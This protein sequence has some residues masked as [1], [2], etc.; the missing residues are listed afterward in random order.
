MEARQ[1]LLV[2]A[3][4]GDAA[5]V[6]ARALFG[7]NVVDLTVLPPDEFGRWIVKQP[8][9]ERDAW[10]KACQLFHDRLG[11]AAPALQSPD[12]LGKAAPAL[13]SPDRLGK[14][15]PALQSPARDDSNK[16]AVIERTRPIRDKDGL[17]TEMVKERLML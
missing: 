9:P 7:G 17:I 3:R 11:K 8:R 1:M 16:W 4:H 2:S 5:G 15:A 14:A 12:R 13:Q 10:I 6:R